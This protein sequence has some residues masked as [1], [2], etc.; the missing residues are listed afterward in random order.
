MPNEFHGK[1]NRNNWCI[2]TILSWG[3]SNFEPALKTNEQKLAK[4]LE[5]LLKKIKYE[6]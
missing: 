4:T 5:I 1:T 3:L 6:H 2:K